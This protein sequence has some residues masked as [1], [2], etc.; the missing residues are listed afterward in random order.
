MSSSR[1]RSNSHDRRNSSA[2]GPVGGAAAMSS[3]IPLSGGL[4][5]KSGG[6][7][8]RKSSKSSLIGNPGLARSE[9]DLTKVTKVR[10]RSAGSARDLTQLDPMSSTNTTSATKGQ[11]RPKMKTT[12][13]IVSS[14]PLGPPQP[15]GSIGKKSQTL[16]NS[17]RFTT[18]ENR[19]FDQC[20][21][22]WTRYVICSGSLKTGRF[23]Y[24]WQAAL[25]LIGPI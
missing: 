3:S 17:L 21:L 5:A 8:E 24:Q 15:Q 16:T 1:R 13:M 12:T 22:D 23:G 10:V 7:K 19:R 4:D 2:A 9:R 6:A 14:D 20:I 11:A 18:G 25:A